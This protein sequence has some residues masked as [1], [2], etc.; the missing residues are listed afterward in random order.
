MLIEL[1]NI[2]AIAEDHILNGACVYVS[3]KTGKIEKISETPIKGLDVDQRIDGQGLYLSPGFI[4]LHVHG[5][6]GFEFFDDIAA[7]ETA[8]MAHLAHG[9]TGILPTTLAA[10]I[11]MLKKTVATIK[12][13]KEKGGT[14][15]LGVHLEGPYLSPVQAG[16]QD[17]GSLTKPDPHDY[18]SLFEIWPNGIKMMGAAPELEGAAELG[19]Y[20]HRQGCVASIAHSNAS[21]EQVEK[22]IAN[23]YTDVTHLYSGCSTVIREK[24]Y[25]IAG[26]VEAGLY[27][28]ELTVQIIADGRHLPP[29]LLK[30]IYKVKG[31]DKITLVT[32][33][34]APA[35]CAYE[36]GKIIRQSNGV[37]AVLEDHIMKLESRDVF[38]GSIAT[39][40]TL[41]RNMIELAKVP[42]YS[43][44]KMATLTPARVIGIDGVKGK[45][46]EGYDAD[47]VLFDQNIN[48]KKVILAGNLIKTIY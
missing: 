43:A 12:A 22:A 23:R 40:D 6:G 33:A 35:G 36:E 25:R 2:N 42:L 20:L 3:N 34:L 18:E 28:D 44:V 16:A 27:F 39:M 17:P 26:V 9:T 24:G 48:V 47:M 15:I 13:A 10:P 4:D 21:F 19:E 45:L 14:N 32:D 8:C 41:V 31:D 37:T 5:G 11:E 30:Y 1:F 38:A 46:A 7:V 29:S